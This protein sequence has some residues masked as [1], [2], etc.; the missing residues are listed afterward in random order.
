MKKP[1]ALQQL[2]S[3]LDKR[4]RR[5]TWIILG[6]TL[7]TG[8]AQAVGVFSVFPFLNVA[9]NPS[10]IQENDI[11]RF[12]Y[13]F[14]GFT[15]GLYFLIFLG[16][17]VFLALLF[18]NGITTLT[19]YA[20]TRFSEMRN[21]SISSRLL[22]HYMK[23]D[24][25]FYSSRNSSDLVKNVIQEVTQLIGYL[26]SFFDLVVNASILSFILATILIIDFQTSLLA[27][28]L[29]GTVYV[30]LTMYFRKTIR[31][32]GEE[33]NAANQD[34]VRF[35][36]EGLNSYKTTK[37]M[38]VEDYYVSNYKTHSLIFA[39]S[40]AFSGAAAAV[41]RYIIEAI[42]AG[43]IVLFVVIEISLGRPLETLAPLIGL[44]GL[45]GYRMLPALQAVYS[46]YSNISY[47]EPIVERIYDDVDRARAYESNIGLETIER[48]PFEQSITFNRA[49][50]QYERSEDAVLKNISLT[51]KKNSMVGIVGKTG[52]G[53][54]TLM[55]LILG[56]LYVNDGTMKVD[57]T[58]INA[59]NVKQ[60]QAQIGYV[61][62]EIYLSDDTVRK[63]IAF[64][65]DD[66]HIDDARV[67]KV[68]Q[69]A[70]L[71]DLV[72][73]LPQQAQTIVGERGVRLSGGERQ[74][75]GIARALYRQPQL[76]V[77][78]EATSSLD[79][80][81][82]EEVLQ[83]IQ[84]AAKEITIIMVAHRLNTL[85]DCD[86]IHVM[87][88]GQLVDQ[89]TYQELLEKNVAFQ[90]MAKLEAMQQESSM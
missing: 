50:F 21:H 66:A 68:I 85:V 53:K 48:I 14:F 13:E 30:L 25:Q 35:A 90:Q 64:G 59:Q 41:P 46:A 5:Q 86:V 69:M 47:L 73:R 10:Q 57:D 56:L 84:R 72:N 24:Y 61:P 77:L 16:V 39:R 15:R 51:I 80:K 40:N 17:V 60:W 89:G 26:M 38:G 74:R 54:T 19:I 87:Q 1:N 4:E 7:I 45:A 27:A 23:N 70:A 82:E 44:F 3:L 8:F 78:D 67:T 79:G 20:K 63:N 58:V 6:L 31:R 11:F 9:L 55:D 22:E 83:A 34:R 75:I 29:F 42:A 43:G 28:G 62:Q 71:E 49:T 52:S 12:M 81:T 88:Q 65:L 37:V 32:K 76:L 33:R 2:F 18:S 36:T